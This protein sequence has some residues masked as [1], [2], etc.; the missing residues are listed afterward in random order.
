[1]PDPVLYSLAML[2]CAAVSMISML[3]VAGW[4]QTVISQPRIH[5]AVLLGAYLGLLAGAYLLQLPVKWPPASALSRMLVLVLPAVLLLEWWLACRRVNGSWQW[6][7][8]GALTIGAIYV[9]LHHSVY[10]SG[11]QHREWS[12]TTAALFMVLAA[13]TW[14]VVWR[15][16]IQLQ[17]RASGVSVVLSAALTI[18]C[19]G[20]TIMLAG[21][22]AGGE[23]AM[24]LATAVTVVALTAA[25]RRMDAGIE[26]LLGVGLIGLASLLMI[27]RLFGGLSNEQ[28]L[29]LGLAPLVGWLA[30]LPWLR[31]LAPWQRGTLRVLLVMIPLAALLW[32][33]KLDF[34]RKLA[35]L[36]A[37]S[38]GG[39]CLL[40]PGDQL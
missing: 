6:L 10:L 4:R 19:T 24:L 11:H 33:A 18:Q 39:Y 5:L 38:A 31:R 13:A 22:L 21:Y 15:L 28:S 9:L 27:G 37:L 8:R 30:E 29:L 12:P 34:D 25:M 1:M 36:I 7:A 32:A 14:T 17:R 35:P 16:L 23:A 20:M 26:A 3:T 40:Q 2:V